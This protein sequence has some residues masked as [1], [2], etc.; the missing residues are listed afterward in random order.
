MWHRLRLAT[1]RRKRIASTVSGVDSIDSNNTVRAFLFF[2]DDAV[3]ELD[4]IT[5]SL[6]CFKLHCRAR[7]LVEQACN[8]IGQIETPHELLAQRFHP[9]L[10][11]LEKRSKI[12]FG[13]MEKANEQLDGT[14]ARTA[15]QASH[16]C[17]EHVGSFDD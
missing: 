8:H 2:V 4:D 3:V 7:M 16:G 11:T 1:W 5:L 12:I 9:V 6:C 17:V 15:S 10:H 13:F 14:I